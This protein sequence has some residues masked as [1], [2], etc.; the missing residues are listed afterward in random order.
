[1]SDTTSSA[2][3]TGSVAH[4]PRASFSD[5]KSVGLLAMIGFVGLLISFLVASLSPDIASSIAAALAT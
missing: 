3:M 2:L 5:L 4:E 1:M